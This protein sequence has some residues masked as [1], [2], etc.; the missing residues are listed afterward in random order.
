[1]FPKLEFRYCLEVPAG[2]QTANMKYAIDDEKVM[3]IFRVT[4]VSPTIKYS[5]MK[6]R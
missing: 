4:H 3:A 5:V 1:V 2:S 6:C